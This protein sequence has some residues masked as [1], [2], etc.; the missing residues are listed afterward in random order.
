MKRVIIFTGYNE[1]GIKKMEEEINDWFEENKDVSIIE[2]KHK[3][4]STSTSV[5]VTI[6]IW[7]EIKIKRSN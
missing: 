2:I 5:Y 3:Q 7:Y 4:S 6:S 1:E